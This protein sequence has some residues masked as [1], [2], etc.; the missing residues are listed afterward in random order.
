MCLKYTENMG[1]DLILSPVYLTIQIFYNLNKAEFQ[2]SFGPKHLTAYSTG[3]VD[4]YAMPRL[5]AQ[6]KP[7]PSPLLLHS[8]HKLD[9]RSHLL[10]VLSADF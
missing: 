8:P 4:R 2:S 7:S 5:L 6:S 3:S 9:T 10:A 1:E